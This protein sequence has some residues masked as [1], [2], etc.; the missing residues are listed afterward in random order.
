MNRIQPDNPRRSL[1]Q[2][3]SHSD[4]VSV[5]AEIKRASPSKGVLCESLNAARMAAIYEK[6]GAAA[7]SV[8]TDRQFFMGS[9]EDLRQVRT[10]S[11]LPVMRK[12][13]IISEY[14][15][16]ESAALGADAIL[17]IA[18]IL[19]LGQLRQYLS[20]CRDLKLEALVEVHSLEDIKKVSQTEAHLIGINNRDLATF[21][22]QLS[23]ALELRHQ[24]R[25]DQIPIVASGIR[26]EDDVRLNCRAGLNNFLIGESLVRAASP[27]DRLK[28]FLEVCYA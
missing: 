20:L 11:G 14:Q 19:E 18:R 23:R 10:A 22:T 27:G 13:F 15:V 9:I 26:N 28:S 25:R 6:A 7:I 21:D 3:L 17:L 2:A 12:E 1:I 4:G 16:V 24:L 5:I 8:L